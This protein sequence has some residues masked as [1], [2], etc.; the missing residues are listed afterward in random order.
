MTKHIA[1][2]PYTPFPCMVG[3]HIKVDGVM[4]TCLTPC[5][6][7]GHTV[8]KKTPVLKGLDGPQLN[9]GELIEGQYN[10]VREGQVPV[11]FEILEQYKPVS[12]NEI[13]GRVV[14]VCNYDSFDWLVMVFEDNTYV[15]LTPGRYWGEGL[16]LVTESINM[17]DLRRLGLVPDSVWS[18]YLAQQQV[19]KASAEQTI[20]HQQLTSAIKALGRQTV[21]KLLET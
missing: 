12:P 5:T 11:E 3:S 8:V 6:V 10:G 7:V 19:G 1:Y 13:S 4:W 17:D 18:T 9:M 15:K 20:G 21:L 16:R 2:V 14:K